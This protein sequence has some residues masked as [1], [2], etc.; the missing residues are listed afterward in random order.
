MASTKQPIVFGVLVGE[1]KLDFNALCENDKFA[2]YFLEPAGQHEV[3]SEA[4]VGFLEALDPRLRERAEDD[5]EA[6]VAP[7]SSTADDQTWKQWVAFNKNLRHAHAPGADP[8]PLTL[9]LPDPTD[10]STDMY[11]LV[12]VESRRLHETAEL[13][14]R[15]ER[16]KARFGALLLAERIDWFNRFCHAAAE[17]RD[18]PLQCG[19]F[20]LETAPGGEQVFAVG[21]A[22]TRLQ[23]N[24]D[25]GDAE[26]QIDVLEDS[27]KAGLILSW[28]GIMERPFLVVPEFPM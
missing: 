18:S 6:D 9:P 17:F 22:F 12:H 26:K 7:V 27:N 28:F 14:V 15:Q 24:A 8:V 5:K 19:A 16:T 11:R 1:E 21:I 3:A 4:C 20:L 13:G 25:F 10:D 2:R 23:W